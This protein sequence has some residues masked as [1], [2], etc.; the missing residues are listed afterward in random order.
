MKRLAVIDGKSVFYRGYYAMPGLSLPDGTPTGGVFGFTSIAI[1]LIKKLEP[2]YVAVA[3]DIKGTSAAKRLEIYPEYKAGRTKPSEDFYAQL[4]ILREVLEAFNWPLYEL[5]QYEA[6]DIMGTFAAQAKENNVE[7]CLITGDYDLLQLIDDN[8]GVYITRSG[9]SD[10]VRYDDEAFE[11]KYGVK[12]SQFVDYKALVGDSSDNIPGVPRIGPKAAQTLLT[13]YND[14]D[15]IYAHL[16]EVKGSQQKY[17][18]DGKESAYMSKE[19]AGIYTDAPIKIDWDETSIERTRVDKIVEV[20]HKYE[21]NSL[22]KRLPKHMKLGDEVVEVIE[23][24]K[25]EIAPLEQV[26]WPSPLMIDGPVFV[27]VFGDD[28][29]ISTNGKTASK[30]A[31]TE[32]DR[33]FWH[34]LVMARTVTYDAKALYHALDKLGAAARFDDVHDLR[35][36]AFLLD[37]LA[38]D[39]S[40]A[41][42]IGDTTE[43]P[44][45]IL[46]G[47]VQVYETQKT[48]FEAETRLSDIAYTYDFPLTY[49][50]FQIEKTGVKIDPERFKAL[51]DKLG[52]EHAKLEQ[53]MYTM[54]GHEFNIGS[55]AQLSEVLFTKL[56]LP[57]QGIKKGKTGYSTGQAELDKL[58]GQHPIIELIEQT[59]EL[60]KLKNT[61]VDSLP[62]LVDA[63]NRIHTTFNQDVAATGRL[64]ST[65]PNLQNIPIRT[66]KGRQIREAFIAD[67]DNV[68]VSADYSQFE[69]RLAGIL[70]NDET[71]INDFNGD[72]DIHTKTASEV[73]GIAMDDVT[74]DQ[75]RA[76][77]V[78]N[79]GVL[80][81]MSPHGLS[82]ATGMSFPQAKDFIDQYFE[83]RKPIRK[84]IDDTLAKARTE[85]YVETF[86]G[87]RRPTPDIQ[88]SNF[89]VRAGAER[90][91]AN[92]PIQGTE[93]DLMKRAMLQVDQQIGD[94][95]KQILQI[96]D[97]ILVE[98]PKENVE[99]VTELLK[100]IMEGVAPELKISLRVD[101]H[102]GTSWGDL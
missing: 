15:G 45:V 81:G 3:W 66:E 82:A 60:A 77:K 4:P 13:T 14:L 70:A 68:L 84:F 58:R 31:I 83:L 12:V 87:R 79:F 53:E 46:A 23:A 18:T 17:L 52:T 98:C 64:S 61:Y 63:N 39:R 95:G 28:V 16:D 73:Y 88:S 40:V 21:F 85:G 67:G 102:S 6:D 86:Y 19:L 76:A 92:M 41:A 96:H 32:V 42:L 26:E 80:Y 75:R 99:K 51:S 90:A 56:K 22:V 11:K 62:K 2:D 43:D 30:K 65:D 101:V 1:E 72:V 35:Q 91:A 49:T 37:P 10:L 29:W 7:A 25:I 94:L 48:A 69:L 74:K 55:P 71:L 20:L 50:L 36:G 54:V 57:T 89:M 34:A 78:I 59:R 27:E 38:R 5:D 33:N 8:T 24:E 9:S 100:T 97:S 47:L 93:A 44:L